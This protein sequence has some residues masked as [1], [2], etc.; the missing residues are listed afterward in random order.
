MEADKLRIQQQEI[1]QRRIQLA[2]DLVK[3]RK[4]EEEERRKKKPRKTV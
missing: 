1:I 3:K 4:L 2:A